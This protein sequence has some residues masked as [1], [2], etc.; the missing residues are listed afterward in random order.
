MIILVMGPQASGKGTQAKLLVKKTN[1]AYF[2]AGDVLRAK[3]KEETPLGREINL[4]INQ[5]G[6]LVA[7]EL[8]EKIVREWLESVDFRR[9]VVF[10]GYPR[11]L[12]QF[13]SLEKLLKEKGQRINRVYLLKVDRAVSLKRLSA[14]RV[15]PKC[16]LEYNLVSR[17]PKK[18]EL[19]DDC[20]LKLS[21]RLDD[22]PEIIKKRLAI[23]RKMTKP[24]AIYLKKQGV[25]ESVDGER[26]V[27]AI[28]QDILARV[29]KLEKKS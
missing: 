13:Q 1:S 28:H 24:L 7:D 19:C 29:K 11:N 9:G 6:A 4:T 12:I 20:G 3:A 15:C 22:K 25:L 8:M 18:G 2:E 27:E 26:S 21:Q 14:R 5:K 16:D 23:Y 10:D 17:P